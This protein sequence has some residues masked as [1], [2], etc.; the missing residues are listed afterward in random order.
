MKNK[1]CIFDNHREK[2]ENGK[3][4]KLS[5]EVKLAPFGA[6][7]DCVSG[8]WGVYFRQIQ[9]ERTK[10]AYFVQFLMKKAEF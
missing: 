3:I 8:F 6:Y 5:M 4:L 2:L 10:G 1:Y 7:K 9:P